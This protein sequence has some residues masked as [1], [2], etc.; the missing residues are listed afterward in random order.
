M[1][2]TLSSGWQENRMERGAVVSEFRALVSTVASK[3]PLFLMLGLFLFS[4][5][6]GRV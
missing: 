6:G 5:L 4:C 3:W 2:I 1:I